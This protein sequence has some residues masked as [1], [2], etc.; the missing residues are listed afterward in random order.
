VTSTSRIIRRALVVCL[1][2]GLAAV[3][4]YYATREKPVSVAVKKI[5][6]GRVEATVSNTRS[7][8]V[9]ACLRAKLA[10]ALGGQIARLAVREGDVVS[11]GEIL[12]EIWNDDMKAEVGLAQRE[13]EAGRSAAQEA[14]FL[15][16]EAERDARRFR[17]LW[18]KNLLSESEYDKANTRAEATRASCDAALAR[19]GVSEARLVV[20]RSVFEKT[21]LRAPFGGTVAEVNGEVGEFIT[22]SPTGVA[23]LPAVDLID[24]SCL[25][26][27]APIDEVDA[28]VIRPGMKARITLDAFPGHPFPGK[29]KRVAPYVLELEKQARTVEVETLFLDEEEGLGGLLPGYS[30]DAEI[31]L[32]VRDDVLRIPTEAVMDGERVLVYDTGTKRLGQRSIKA[33]L[34]NWRYTEV[35]SG[36]KE[37]DAVV[38]SVGREGVGP[39]VLVKPE[40]EAGE[41]GS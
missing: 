1:L 30:A 17:S 19:A 39:G 27:S 16:A 29:V 24:N 33:G 14:C 15:A 8:T 20:A 21:V 37:G 22:P 5:D 34:S 6:R 35:L 41:T 38:T 10:P 7:G 18:E 13:A 26:V 36:L 32:E 28:P 31:V 11:K 25:Y 12:L 40:D 2:I 9:K 3:I 23:T 4:F